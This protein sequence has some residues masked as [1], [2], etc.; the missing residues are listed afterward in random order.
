[1][2][3]HILT[4]LTTFVVAVISRFGYPGLFVLMTLENV[5]P[6]LPSEI[7][8]PF[9]GYLAYTGRFNLWLVATVGA[10]G[11]NVGS[12]I[13]YWF[14]AIGARPFLVRHGKYMLISHREIATA[15]RW[16]D[17]YG[18]WAVFFSRLLPLVRSLIALPAGVARM[19]FWKFHVFTFLGSWIWCFLL[20]YAGYELGEHWPVLRTYF[21]RFDDVIGILLVLGVTAYV[22]IQLRR[23]RQER[24]IAATEPTAELSPPE[25]SP[26]SPDVP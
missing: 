19:N 24:R 13:V 4:L 2:I 25:S 20:A 5:F 8:L 26:E 21:Q 23:L 9:A 6:P 18:Q 14:G 7:I 10:I 1:M 11:C 17:K 15:D 12:G 3:S 22:W 16:F